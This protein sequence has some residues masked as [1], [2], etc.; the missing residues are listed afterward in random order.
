[1]T[2]IQ[3]PPHTLKV[4]L[5][6]G[7][8]LR[9][10]MCGIQ[11]IR[12]RPGGPYE[13]LTLRLARKISQ[14]LAETDWTTK[15]EFTL[16][17]EP[18]MNERAHEIIGVFREY[19]P[20]THLMV[21]TNGLPLLRPPGV[22]ANLDRLFEAGL[23]ILAMDCYAVSKK[24]EIQ[25]RQY[26]DVPLSDYPGPRSPYTRVA[27][28]KRYIIMMEDFEAAALKEG[29]M[30]TKKVNNHCGAGMPPLREPMKKRCGR[31]FREMII[32]QDG[33]V[34]LCCNSW[35]DEYQCGSV[36]DYSGLIEAWNN[37]YLEAARR[38][39]YQGDRDFGICRVCN[40][41]TYRNGLLPD[42]MGKKE[43]RARP[44]D[45]RITEEAM[46]KGPATKPV[47][48]PWEDW[49]KGEDL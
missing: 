9:C 40:E 10:G 3:D 47:S 5:T 1:M 36:F 32:R 18:L 7:C 26:T 27:A 14:M 6:E 15:I 39:L 13:F 12:E 19:N 20:K 49:A 2:Y 38:R 31:P 30:G 17:G 33:R 45:Y 42:R 25:V 28:S 35:R 37:Q 11:G 22:K 44:K 4:E 24:A 8:N 48:R 29:K 16:R 34:A 41:T 23:N 21:T 46:S 43:I